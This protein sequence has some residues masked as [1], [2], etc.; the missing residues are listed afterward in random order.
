MAT[1]IRDEVEALLGQ[2]PLPEQIAVIEHWMRRLRRTV[3]QPPIAPAQ[4]FYGIW[5][6]HFPEDFDVDTTLN[7][8][9]HEW[10]DI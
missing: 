7:A 4:D 8:I 9:R 6:D 10:L 1:I 5:R 3:A 2:L